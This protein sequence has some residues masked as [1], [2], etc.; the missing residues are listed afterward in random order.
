MPIWEY[1]VDIARSS[2]TADVFSAIA[3]PRRREVLG[4][5]ARGE[6]DVTRLVAELRWP[7][8]QVSKHLGV[9]RRAGLVS[10]RREGRNR[11]Y[12]VNGQELQ[13]V[14]DWVKGYERFWE[15]QLQR[16][17]ERAEREARSR[18]DQPNQ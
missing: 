3:L 18:Q 4:A 12:S 7:Q 9:L 13:T 15:H 2:A 16:I 14:Y 8:P 6:R 10:V 11:L 17:R 5:L 1:D